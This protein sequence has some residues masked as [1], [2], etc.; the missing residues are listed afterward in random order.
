MSRLQLAVAIAIFLSLVARATSL[1]QDSEVEA[2]TMDPVVEKV[3][4]AVLSAVLSLISGFILLQARRR[5]KRLAYDLVQRD[6]LGVD[7]VISKDI[8]VTYKNKPAADITFFSCELRN[9]GDFVVKDESLRFDFGEGAVVL[10]AYIDPTPPREYGAGEV[11]ASDLSAHEKKFQVGHLEKGHQVKFNFVVTG[12]PS[13]IRLYP[14]NKEG[15]VEVLPRAVSG[16]QD[17]R[18][19]L[20]RFLMLLVLSTI[21]PP[22]FY[23]LPFLI[24]DLAG[25]LVYLLFALAMLPLLP[26]AA[27]VIA[28]AVSNLAR[29]TEQSSVL[30]PNLHLEGGSELI[31]IT[32]GASTI[33]KTPQEPIPATS[34]T[35]GGSKA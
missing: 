26:A 19:S 24:G 10:D 12:R 20:Q 6:A 1:G 13:A 17:D 34:A 32:G 11:D 27:K 3:I 4:I 30:L 29:A 31:I 8:Q 16:L 28:G 5:R 15:D 21:V 35:R 25:P 33:Q 18:A 2:S 14:Y 23:R 7:E 22:V 9:I